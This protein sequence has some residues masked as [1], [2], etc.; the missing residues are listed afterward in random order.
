MAEYEQTVRAGSFFPSIKY[1]SLFAMAGDDCSLFFDLENLTEKQK[2]DHLTNVELTAMLQI[3]L[4]CIGNSRD[5][6]AVY[7]AYKDPEW[8]KILL[9]YHD[10]YKRLVDQV[11]PIENYSYHPKFSF[12]DSVAKH[13]NQNK[14]LVDVVNLY[15]TSGSNIII[16]Q[17]EELLKINRNVNSKKHFAENAP[18]FGIPTPDTIVVNKSELE[19][20]K[21]IDFFLKYNNKIIIKLLG[22]AGSRNV[23][24][25]NS[26]KEAN[27][28]VDEYD[29]SMI[30]LLQ[31]KLDLENFTEM[32][33]DLC[34]SD[35]DIRI[36]NTRKILF[37]DGLWVGNLISDSVRV[38]PEHQ[39]ILIQVGEYA[40]YHGYVSPEGSNCGIDFFVGKNGEI[41]VTEINAR[42]TGGLFPAE[43]LSQIN[44]KRD[45]IPFFDIVP[46]EKK[47]IYVDF[48]DK[49][50]VGEF[51]GEFAILPIG[52]G[53][54]PVP[55][56]G[57]DYFYTWQAAI[58]DLEA[59]KQKKNSELG[60]DVL[61][62]ADKIVL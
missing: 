15:M 16:H 53:C 23:A 2:E 33:V 49:Y 31:E 50:L 30:I 57:R 37:A 18:S 59:F 22:L 34:I 54:F 47:D 12:Y 10:F 40:R 60:N 43:I 42:W 4:T 24:S 51:E 56:E 3:A 48:I 35:E 27:H 7:E 28:Y 8:N 20:K 6:L 25:V 36:A 19:S 1:S 41:S 45:A 13:V 58:G 5:H 39:E 26:V 14:D 29:D 46:I 55:I 52:F 17:N 21:V 9:R 11:I 32:T 44:N 38:S 62:T 61:P